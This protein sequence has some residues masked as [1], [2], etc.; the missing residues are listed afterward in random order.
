MSERVKHLRNAGIVVL[1]A[2]LVWTVPGGSTAGSGVSNLLS[3]LLLAGLAFF[4]FRL[5]MEH[6]TTLLDLPDDQRMILYGSVTLALV[7]LLATSRMWNAAP[8]WILVWFALLGT[9]A[10]GLLRVVRRWRAY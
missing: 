9:A 8:A 7:T 5:Y 2:V 1:L 3:L 4:A 6:R 10:Y